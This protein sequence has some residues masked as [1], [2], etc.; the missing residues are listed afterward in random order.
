MTWTTQA[1]F[2]PDQA[3]VGLATATWT[4][5]AGDVFMF[6]LRIKATAAGANAFVAAAIAARNAWRVKNAANAAGATTLL[7]KLIAADV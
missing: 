7:N 2:D 4:E 5:L 1:Q 6:S 3:D